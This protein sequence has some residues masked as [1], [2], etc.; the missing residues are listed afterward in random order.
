MTGSHRCGPRRRGV[1]AG[2]LLMSVAATALLLSSCG[3]D[4][5]LAGTSPPS[6]TPVASSSTVD[7]F[8]FTFTDSTGQSITLAAA[9]KRIISYSPG[10]TEA[11]FAVGAGAQLVAVD[12]FSDFPEQTKSLP[13]LEYSKP[14]PE[15][16]VGYAP[17]LVIMATRQEGQVSQFRALGLTVALIREPA[18]LQGLTEQMELI[19]RISGHAVGGAQLATGMRNR[20]AAVAGRVAKLDRGARVFY[21]LSPDGFTVAPDTFIGAML[22]TL[23]LQNVAVGAKTAF[24]Q[25]SAEVVIAG[26]PEIIILADGGDA[27]GQTAE[28]VKARPGWATINAVKNG[29]VYVI[30]ST[31]F[32]RPGPRIVDALDQLMKLIFPSLG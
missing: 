9:P 26:D 5:N 30:D 3:R 17:D 16:A 8:P 2:L 6:P 4:D 20:I 13:K 31:I 25:L 7:A 18:N 29:R 21:E 24:P 28:L 27:G 11:L 32:S 12:K 19:G 22:S 23:R 1:L 15:P 10:A 14:A